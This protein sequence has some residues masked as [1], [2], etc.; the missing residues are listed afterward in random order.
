[1]RTLR[2][3]RRS[4]EMREERGVAAVEFAIV[5]LVFIMLLFGMI[6]FGFVFALQHNMT[7]AASEGARAA[8]K[9]PQGDEIATAEDR[10]DAALSFKT[11]SDHAIVDAQIL[12]G[13]ECEPA[14][15]TIR[16]LKVTITL[17]YDAHPVIPSLFGV[18]TPDTMTASATVELEN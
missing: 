9:A 1:M 16:C 18:G 6:S 10:A 17:D 3:L 15:P 2:L 14:N 12:T 4:R 7:H 8:L 5:S 11:A 13:N